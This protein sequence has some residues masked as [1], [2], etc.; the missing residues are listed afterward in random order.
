MYSSK[1]FIINIF[2]PDTYATLILQV[3]AEE[4]LAKV[5]SI[6]WD[7]CIKPP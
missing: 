2:E 1:P 5:F 3:D 7:F 4:T 6:N